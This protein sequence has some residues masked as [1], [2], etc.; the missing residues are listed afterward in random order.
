VLSL[1]YVDT[2]QRSQL[3]SFAAPNRSPNA[4][5]NSAQLAFRQSLFANAFGEVDRANV[6]IARS[7]LKASTDVRDESIEETLM[8]VLTLFW[9]AYVAERNHRQNLN[10]QKRYEDLIKDV[11]RR[12]GYALTSPA[13]LPRLEAEMQTSQALERTSWVDYTNAVNNLLV[14]LRIQTNETVSLFIPPEIPAMPQ[15]PGVDPTTMRAV[16]VAETNRRNAELNLTAVESQ[17]RPTIDLV[18]RARTTGSD[19]NHETAR[20]EMG[21]GNH[22]TYFVGVELVAPLWSEANRGLIADARVQ[23]MIAENDA[24]VAVDNTKRLLNEAA[25]TAQ[26]RFEVVNLA[27]TTVEK[28][29]RVVTEIERAYR[30]GR[31]QLVEVI[32]AYNDLSQARFDRATAVG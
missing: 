6:E 31:Q 12:K 20:L 18:A 26:A 14:A 3:S 24:V 13:E 21:Q 7:A 17:V 32:R 23:K 15:L 8:N 30:Q 22:P 5:L 16:K 25:L 11:R 29:E 4:N 1:E 10:T 28:R 19:P 27:S 2:R 9:N